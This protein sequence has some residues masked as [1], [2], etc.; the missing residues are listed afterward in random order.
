MLRVLLFPHRRKVANPY[1][2]LLTDEASDIEFTDWTLR[3]ALRRWDVVH[4]HWPETIWSS[5]SRPLRLLR[6]SAFLVLLTI[7]RRRGARIVETIHNIEPHDGVE[8]R[9]APSMRN[10]LTRL[11]DGIQILDGSSLARL[12][13]E[14]AA[15]PHWVIPHG[16]Y[17]ERLPPVTRAPGPPFGI[18][19]VGFLRPYKGTEELIE[20]FASLSL[21]QWQLHIAGE[22]DDPARAD[23]LARMTAPLAGSF[24]PRFLSSEEVA[25]V[26]ARSHLCVLPFRAIENSGSVLMALSLGLPVLA[27]DIGTLRTLRERVG[28][29][30]VELYDPPLSPVVL[31]TA[32]DR[33]EHRGV[34]RRPDLGPLSW[35][36]IRLQLAEAYRQLRQSPANTGAGRL[37]MR[38]RRTS[39]AR[40]VTDESVIHGDLTS[41]QPSGNS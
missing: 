3:D 17:G 11:L 15:L 13:P 23:D 33:A 14:I 2:E 10:R 31:A 18:F 38:A 4:I 37:Q 8:D 20:C 22:V 24:R 9:L 21:P 27:P 25:E 30:W 39:K 1:L 40:R 34:D 7:A 32:L 6:G 5:G 19:H 29:G 36:T 26:A 35:P 16:H 12:T 28:E 41:G